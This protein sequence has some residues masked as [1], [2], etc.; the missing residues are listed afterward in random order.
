MAPKFRFEIKGEALI[1]NSFTV[2]IMQKWWWKYDEFELQQV[3]KTISYLIDLHLYS[4][5]R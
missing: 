1:R 5:L 3:I 2:K 4:D